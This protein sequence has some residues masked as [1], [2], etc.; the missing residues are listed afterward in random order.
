MQIIT[1]QKKALQD[2]RKEQEKLK[3]EITYTN[4]RLKETGVKRKITTN[5]LRLLEKKIKE[6]EKLIRNYEDEI[7]I[8]NHT[9]LKNG[10]QIDTLKLEIEL[11]RKGYE[12]AIRNYYNL[13]KTR[14]NILFYILG[15]KSIN[16]AYNRIRYIREFMNYEKKT[17][18]E[19]KEKIQ[20]LKRKND[21]LVVIINDR[22]S[23]LGVIKQEKKEYQREKDLK[24]RQITLLRRKENELRK[25]IT[26]K[27]RIALELKKEIKRIIEEE[28]KLVKTPGR[29]TP[30]EKIISKK[31]G[32][33]MGR[34]PWPTG[35]GV[36]IDDFGEKEHPVLK[37]VKVKNDGIDI[38]TKEGEKARA[39]FE[40]KVS[41]VVAI[42]GANEVVIIRHGEYISVYQNLINVRVRSGQNIKTKEI[43][44]Q[45]YT[46]KSKKETILHFEIWKG[47]TVQNPEKWIAR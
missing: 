8:I 46:D 35:A 13:T 7:E 3:S 30:E 17:Y 12:K 9:I 4:K 47:R 10:R 2:I 23:L 29:I 27:R 45:I 19:L 16:Q 32:E 20:E 42:P 38:I 14:E 44:G 18:D 31:F 22:K 24:N 15:A 41:R 28:R 26:K 11:L 33:N 25:E 6:R 36:I 1:A 34:L 21:E 40:G 37:N 43:I 39:V 5:Q